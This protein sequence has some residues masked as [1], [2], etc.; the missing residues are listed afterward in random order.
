MDTGIESHVEIKND[1]LCFLW[2]DNFIDSIK[3][4]C[5]NVHL[6]HKVCSSRI[7]NWNIKKLQQ[8][9]LIPLNRLLSKP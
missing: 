6:F 9:S 5:M 7:A 2:R 8:T 4:Y 1:V 3:Y